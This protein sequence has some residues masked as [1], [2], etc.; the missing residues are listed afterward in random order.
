MGSGN[1]FH[2]FIRRILTE[3]LKYAHTLL[4]GEDPSAATANISTLMSHG[5]DM[6]S[7]TLEV[8]LRRP[9]TLPSC[10]FPKGADIPASGP[11][12]LC[13]MCPL[14]GSLGADLEASAQMALP[15]RCFLMSAQSGLPAHFPSPTLFLS[16][17]QFLIKLIY[18]YPLFLSLL[19]LL[20]LFT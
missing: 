19:Y 10:L 14:P 1:T 3:C 17:P 20:P 6:S 15:V 18:L 7:C 8:S 12:H 5:A 4:R 13:Q 16:L 9:A 2:N 11:A